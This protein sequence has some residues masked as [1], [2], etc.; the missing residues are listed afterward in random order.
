[1]KR[2]Y[3]TSQ[4]QAAVSLIRSVVPDAAITT[5]IIAGFPGETEAEFDEGYQF[6]N[7]I[8]FARIHVF[9]YSI[10]EGTE[11]AVMPGQVTNKVKKQRNQRLL[12]LAKEC[13]TNFNQSFSGSTMSVLWE[14]NSGDIWSGHTG[15]YIKVY[16]RSNEDLSNQILPTKLIEVRRDGMWGELSGEK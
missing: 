1:M 16:T 5:D 3:D 15:N 12:V 8:G 2:H 7:Q 13:A 9:P 11:A 6:C 4:Y 10:R 14:Q